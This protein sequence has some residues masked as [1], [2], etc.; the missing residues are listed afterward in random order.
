VPEFEL[1]RPAWFLIGLVLL[2]WLIYGYRRSLVDFSQLQQG[3]SLAVRC[4][5]VLILA[6]ALAGFTWNHPVRD[7]YVVALVDQSRSVDSAATERA[8]SFLQDFARDQS[9]A[10]VAVLPFA[11]QPGPVE[12]LGAERWSGLDKTTFAP[13]VESLQPLASDLAAAIR[14]ARAAI[15]AGYVP[16]LVLFTDG[17]QTHGDALTAARAAG[18]AIST[19]PIGRDAQPEAQMAAVKA[20]NSVRVGEPFLLEVEIYATQ[21]QTGRWELFRNELQMELGDA[22]RLELQP[23]I[24][25]VRVQQQVDQAQAAHFT[26]RLIADQDGETSDNQASSIVMVSGQPRV[27]LI[28]SDPDS[29]FP[30]RWALEDQQMHVDLRPP[31]GLPSTLEQLLGFDLIVLSDVPAPAF[32]VEQLRLLERYVSEFGGGLM[33][34][35]GEQSFGLGG[36]SETPLSD[37]LPVYSDPQQEQEKP[38]LAMVLVIDRS[39]SMGGLKLDL[40]QDAARGAIELLGPRDQIAILAFDDA[41]YWINPLQSVADKATIVDRIERLTSAGGTNLYPALAEARDALAE[42]AAKLKH[43]IVLTDGISAPADF[44]GM[45]ADLAA[46]QITVSTVA[47]GQK[48]D[49]K[50]LQELAEQGSGRH[51]LCEDPRSVPQIFAQ[52]TLLASKSAIEET[53]FLPQPVRATPVLRGIDL[54]GLPLLLG[55]VVTRPKPTSEVVLVA[56][57]GQPLLAWWRYGLGMSLAF[58]SDAKTRWAAE[59]QSWPDF[60]TFWAQCVRHTMRT[61]QTQQ[62]ELQLSSYAG[63]TRIALELAGPSGGFLNDAQVVASLLAPDRQSARELVLIQ[64][65]PGRYE[66]EVDSLVAGT[67][68]VDLVARAGNELVYRESRGFAVGYPD[69]LRLGPVNESLLKELA[70]ASGGVYDARPDDLLRLARPDARRPTSLSRPLLLFA[71]ILLLLDVALR[72]LPMV[73]DGTVAARR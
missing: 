32:Q 60:A 27:L 40:A 39:G 36:Y 51:Y 5:F 70:A 53:P 22:A 30:L 67:Y 73:G 45:I 29:L 19:I 11:G 52:E 62:G 4:L 49:R 25:R 28:D 18:I 50:L 12:V 47:V 7:R 8:Q 55:L 9:D 34:L 41:P 72:R 68:F 16:Q 56:E 69:E 23:G 57:Q 21:S 10:T 38:S 42:A 54:E 44:A 6:A 1:L 2:P 63:Q 37:V 66:A 14:H 24:N 71:L 48:A 65:A 13:A 20:P 31:A 58:T 26:A 59:W 46:E 33:M 17:R 3:V 61:Q 64:T 35:G 15:P 43:V